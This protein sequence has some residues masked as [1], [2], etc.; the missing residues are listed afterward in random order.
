MSETV[1]R[2]QSPHLQPPEAQ[3]EGNVPWWALVNTAVTS[4]TVKAGNSLTS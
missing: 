1:A 2:K 3:S 4:C